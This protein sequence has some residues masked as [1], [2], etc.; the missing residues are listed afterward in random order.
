VILQAPY[1]EG[2]VSAITDALVWVGGVAHDAVNVL[3]VALSAVDLVGVIEA[4]EKH[5][6]YQHV[7]NMD[8]GLLWFPAN[9]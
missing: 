1:N 8:R 6:L 2:G 9:T 4:P 5:V 7:S 3:C